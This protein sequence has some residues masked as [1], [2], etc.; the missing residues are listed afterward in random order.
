L[1]VA[2][3]PRQVSFYILG[4]S[5]LP[6]V[7]YEPL[8]KRPR[9]FATLKYTLACLIALTIMAASYLNKPQAFAAGPATGIFHVHELWGYSV[10]GKDE[11]SPSRITRIAVDAFLPCE[12]VSRKLPTIAMVLPESGQKECHVGAWSIQRANGEIS[13]HNSIF[14]GDTP[15]PNSSSGQFLLHEGPAQSF[16]NVVYGAA[17]EPGLWASVQFTWDGDWAVFTC[18]LQ[19]AQNVTRSRTAQYLKVNAS[20]YVPPLAQNMDRVSLMPLNDRGRF[21]LF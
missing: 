1:L 6:Q 8:N 19:N 12:T 18:E 9:C 17:I 13:Q 15:G 7:T 5:V 10:D 21:L 20:R 2:D 16:W 4:S 11:W 3:F 14:V